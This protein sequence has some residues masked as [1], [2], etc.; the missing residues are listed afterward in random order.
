MVVRRAVFR[1]LRW[2][3][4]VVAVALPAVLSFGAP[5]VGGESPDPAPSPS[6]AGDGNSPPPDLG[7]I[8][9]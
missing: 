7:L 3:G 6:G 5:T 1:S 2:L 8:P 4:L 9:A